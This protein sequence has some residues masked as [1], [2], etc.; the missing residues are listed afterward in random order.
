MN[1]WVVQVGEPLP[2]D[3]VNQRLWRSGLLAKELQNRGHNVLWWASAFRHSDRKF[4]SDFGPRV[5]W[6]GIQIHLLPSP[7]YRR[8]V[9][10]KRLVDHHVL[11]KALSLEISREPQ[12]A[13][14]HCGYPTLE[15]A[16]TVVRYGAQHRVP[17][18][19]DI[20][21]F[22]PEA[23][24]DVVPTVLHPIADPVIK[25]YDRRLRSMLR[26]ATAVQ[27]HAPGFRDYGLN[28]AG[29]PKTSWDEWYP[30]A[31]A[32]DPPNEADIRRA[33]KRWDSFGLRKDSNWRTIC[34]FGNLNSER[35][36]IDHLAPIRAVRL[37]AAK[38]VKVRI[39]YC[40]SGGS[41]ERIR[42]ESADISNHVYTPGFVSAPEIWA[43]LRR[44]DLGLLPYAPANDFSN[45]LP[46]KAI[47]YL[48]AGVPVITSLT[49]GYL[50]D[51]FSKA[52]CVVAYR[53]S[54]AESFAAAILQLSESSLL[55]LSQNAERL[56]KQN[57]RA[58]FVYARLADQL[59][60]IAT[61][62]RPT[63]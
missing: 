54:D 4:R 8:N 23:F 17:T 30:F 45:S 9:S 3:G 19:I 12:P 7:G 14:I 62:F 35:A 38:G 22:W 63:R 28:K 5:T 32:S 13:I 58:E 61:A 20:R 34:F 39:V 15:T 31:Y 24:R 59:E 60:E 33:E 55:H 50:F 26:G 57:F 42:Q 10:L 49:S 44:S 41:V 29:R 46:N 37:L 52:G 25:H 36:E 40:G 43:L 6:N 27:G 47:E 16:E 53:A 21:D 48:S 2:I 18:V 51:L 11:G 1:I 56:F